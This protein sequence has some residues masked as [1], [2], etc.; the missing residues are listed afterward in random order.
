MALH[1]IRKV[2]STTRSNHRTFNR[3]RRKILITTT[4]QRIFIKLIIIIIITRST[5]IP[6]TSGCAFSSKSATT[7]EHFSTR[8]RT[9]RN[10]RRFT[11]SETDGFRRSFKSSEG[12]DRYIE[13]VVVSTASIFSFFVVVSFWIVAT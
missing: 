1:Y 13:T 10:R 12:G 6:Y 8:T 2:Y 5:T 7:V 11:R 9:N 3:T 4:T